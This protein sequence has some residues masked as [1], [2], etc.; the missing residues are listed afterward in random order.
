MPGTRD[1]AKSAC[2]G[3]LHPSANAIIL[4][5]YAHFS[6]FL[7]NISPSPL[8]PNLFLFASF[9]NFLVFSR[10]STSF[11]LTLSEYNYGIAIHMQ[12]IHDHARAH[13]EPFSGCGGAVLVLLWR[14]SASLKVRKRTFQEIQCICSYT[15]IHG[16]KAFSFL[17]SLL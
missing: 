3:R 9:L 2:C 4:H 14:P 6:L 5:E 11:T 16:T 10:Y 8:S 1:A 7:R 15:N 13:T 17:A 12:L